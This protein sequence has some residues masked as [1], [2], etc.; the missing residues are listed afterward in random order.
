M[1]FFQAR[2]SDF[3]R[4]WLSPSA[5]TFG[6]QNTFDIPSRTS[7]STRSSTRR[8]SSH[9]PE[10]HQ[11]TTN[12][13]QVIDFDSTWR[14][15]LDAGNAGLPSGWADR[16]PCRSMA[17]AG[18]KAQA[19]SVLKMPPSVSR[20]S[21]PYGSQLRPAHLL[22]RDR[23]RLQRHR[24][25]RR[26]AHRTL[27]RRRR[28]FLPKTARRSA[29]S[30]SRPGTVTPTTLASPG[31]G[32]ASLNAFIVTDPPLLSGTNRLSVEVHQS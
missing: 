8:R 25:N 6:A 19:S 5:A 21:P 28:G 27:P 18:T 12:A 10:E 30:I 1:T 4:R 17:P 31:V 20:S 26:H 9:Q 23:L 14:Y 7:S 24:P 22:L 15:N 32:D 3:D 11:G 29:V 13:V 2:H 16:S